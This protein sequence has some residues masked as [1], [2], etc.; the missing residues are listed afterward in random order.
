[1][2]KRWEEIRAYNRIQLPSKEHLFWLS[3]RRDLADRVPLRHLDFHSRP[4]YPGKPLDVLQLYTVLMLEH[5]PRPHRRRLLKLR[6]ADSFSDEIL[7]L[8]NTAP[9]V[10]KDI[11]VTKSASRKDGD[12]G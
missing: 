10:D 3:I 5:P 9:D 6:Q 2:Q 7:R 4:F 1:M 11:R 12:R 8:P